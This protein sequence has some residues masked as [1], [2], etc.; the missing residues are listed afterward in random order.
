MAVLRLARAIENG[1]KQWRRLQNL[2]E[3]PPTTFQIHDD[4]V[5]GMR[6]LITG[7]KRIGSCSPPYFFLPGSWKARD[8]VA[9]FLAW[10]RRLGVPEVVLFE[11]SDLT[12]VRPGCSAAA[13]PAYAASLPILFPLIRCPTCVK[14]FT[15]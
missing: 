9:Q 4:A 12:D 13:N 10:A 11:T 1:E 8:N 5:P 15:A 2:A 6:A 7:T 3:K 14:C